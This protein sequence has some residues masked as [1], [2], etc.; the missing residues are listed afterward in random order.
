MTGS[1]AS[2]EAQRGEIERRVVTVVFC[3]L[4]GF[5]S[6]S[7][8]LDAEDVAIV[9]NAYFEAVR[10]AVGRHGGTLEKFIGDAAVAVFGVP[11][12]GEQDAERAVRCGLAV[13]G[14]I[15]QLATRIGLEDGALHVR[16]G[17]NTGE[18]VVHPAPSTGEAMVTGDVVNTAARLQSAA[19]LNGLLLGPETALAVAHAVDLEPAT[20]LELKGKAQPVRASRAV[21][22]LSEPERERAMGALTA[23]TIGR[24]AE[25]SLVADTLEQCVLG[26]SRQLTVIAPPGTGKSRLLDEVAKLAAA[27]GA[28]VRRAR[29]RPDALS[30]FRPAAELVKHALVSAGIGDAEAIRQTLAKRLGNERALVVADELAAL[31]GVSEDG[32]DLGGTDARRSARFAAWSAGIAALDDRPE[33]WLVEDVHWSGSDYR[34]FLGSATDGTGRLIVCTSRPSLLDSDADWISSG[35]VLE[36]EP[37]S[38]PSTTELVRALVGDALPGE[39]IERLAERSGGNPLF[40]EELLRSWVGSGLLGRSTSGWR[41]ARTIDDVELP[42]TVQSVY[43]AQLDDL[44]ESARSV[45][46]RASVAGRQFPR[47][48][49]GRLGADDGEGIAALQRRGIVAGPIADDLLG[50]S[51]VIRHALLRDVGYASLSRAERARLHV[52]MARWLEEVG[53]DNLD[54]VAEVIGRHYAASLDSTPTLAPDLGDGLTREVAVVLA[55]GWFERAGLAAL[56]AAAYEAA[57]SLF[58]R[59][60]GLTSPDLPADRARRLM[61]LARATAFTADMTTGLQTAETALAVYWDCLRDGSLSLEDIR[62]DASRAVALVGNILAQQ[63]RFHDVVRLAVESLAELGDRDDAVSARL[64]LTR[65]RGA[66]MIGD[67]EWQKTEADRARAL[68]IARRIGDPELELETRMWIVWDEPD[69]DGMRTAWAE[70]ERIAHEL[71]RWPDVAEARRT[72]AGICL[73]DDLGGTIAGAARLAS[74][75]K[76]HELDEPG[77]WADYYVSEA[78]F[79]RGRW[80]E[81]L[82]AGLCAV[83]L[84][85]TRSYHRVAARSWF[86]VVPIAAARGDRATLERAVAWYEP[87]GFPETPYG[88]I[89]RSA[90]DVLI[91]QVGLTTG[92]RVDLERLEPSIAEGGGLPSWFEAVDVVV[93]EGLARGQLVQARRALE[94]FAATLEREPSSTGTAARELLEARIAL[95]ET[96]AFTVVRECARLLCAHD[97]PW[98]RLKCLRLLVDGG[99]AEPSELA[100]AQALEQQLGTRPTRIYTR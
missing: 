13:I 33:V 26:A 84:A 73:P 79:A 6:L 65:I 23:P 37:L 43:A 91:G 17:V 19:P 81:A 21:K 61:G 48:V 82:A 58:E 83:D 16:V 35:E 3:D 42:S 51:F 7:E 40:V 56:A 85:E 98:L 86:V 2:A 29:V 92:F 90:V 66:A 100:S 99:D 53:A 67:E 62:E 34:A 15:E 80:D 68:E 70:I 97:L 22:L 5:T 54:E 27:R 88:L 89:S 59:S 14:A 20:D 57:A 39:L 41:L 94:I 49:L 93:A 96:G 55:A 12:A 95:A 38:Q 25:L 10:Q 69:L 24:A 18:A 71:R 64:L 75:A 36:L 87:L 74:F 63:L 47:D 4:A 46:R 1:G 72:L 60:I 45:I 30:V 31:I 76:A 52:R 9:Q 50:E 11:T 78:E 44:P 32:A 77:A 8:R 28:A